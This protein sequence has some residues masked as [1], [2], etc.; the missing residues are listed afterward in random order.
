MRF[1]KDYE[2]E[3]VLQIM[4][5]LYEYGTEFEYDKKRYCVIGTDVG[6]N[7][8]ECQAIPFDGNYYWFKV[9]GENRVRLL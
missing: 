6:R 7:E 9:C 5:N 4:A 2:G 1:V 8:I 3:K